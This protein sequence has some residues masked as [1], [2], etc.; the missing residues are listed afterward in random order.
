MSS[1][2]SGVFSSMFKSQNNSALAPAIIPRNAKLTKQKIVLVGSGLVGK[3]SIV[4]SYVD[5]FTPDVPFVLEERTRRVQV[6]GLYYEQTIVDTHGQEEGYR[7]RVGC[8]AGT[9]VFLLCFSVV[10][11][12]S[13]VDVREKWYP[14]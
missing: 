7:T 5:K 6:D 3:T 12:T 2:N 11:P 8:Y 10:S 1:F 9:D 13:F 14:E 4:S